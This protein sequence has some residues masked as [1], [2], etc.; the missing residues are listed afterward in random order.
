MRGLIHGSAIIAR[1]RGLRGFFQGWAPSTARQSANSAV[2]FASYET[3]K[4][5]ALQISEQ[6]KLDTVYTFG[7]GG[8]A[9]IITV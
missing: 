2:R 6:E 8:L 3:L 5:Q 7:I 1:E 4:K 9:G